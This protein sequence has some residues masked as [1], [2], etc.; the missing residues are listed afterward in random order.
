[1]N[2]SNGHLMVDARVT[3]SLDTAAALSLRVCPAGTVIFP[4]VGG[5]LHTNKKRIL[6]R[7]AAFD[8]NTM[9]AVPTSAIQPMFLYYWLSAIRLS[10]FAYGAPVPQVSRVR[11]AELHV[12]LPPLMEQKRILAAIEQQ[13]S[14]LDA[15]MAALGTAMQRVRAMRH[16]IRFAAVNGC[17]VA[18]DPS[19]EPAAEMV[20]RVRPTG[21]FRNTSA[22]PSQLPDLPQ[23]WTWA[24]MGRLAR[25]IT[26]GHVGPMKDRYVPEGI[27]FLR[28]QNVRAD[29]FDP[30]GL[31]F[32][33]QE[34]HEE[35]RKSRLE[36]GDLVVVRSGNVG[37]ACVVPDSL[38]EANC[39]DL[40]IVQGPE[41]INPSYAALYMNSLARKWIRTG[42]VGVALTHFNT[43]S[44][45][46]LPVPVPPYPEQLRIVEAAQRLMSITDA[47]EV[48]VMSA[49]RRSQ[50]LRSSI[51]AAAFSGQLVAQ[52]PQDEPASVL[53]DR[54]A[55]ERVQADDHGRRRRIKASSART[56]PKKGG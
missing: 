1:M 29:G 55:A 49:L 5:A 43:Q 30:R 37:T 53:L 45:A 32:I 21:R 26:V 41:A 18:H 24:P 8:T 9:G 25:R 7:S 16:A 13:F 36:P 20:K 17:L 3:V 47:L 52:D 4:K 34:F 31:L 27:P 40:V 48:S 19:D 10:D 39:A 14:W 46:E 15:G 42:R 54:V 28:S 23:G 11:M 51:L 44:V 33:P 22:L 2:T 6:G 12:A 50:Q 35:L 56:L 38:G